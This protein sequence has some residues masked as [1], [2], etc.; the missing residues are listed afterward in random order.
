M[1]IGDIEI[2]P[3]RDGT[4]WEL[5]DDMLHRPG[6][7]DPW[8][9][10]PGAVDEHGRLHFDVGGFLIRS[11]D[12]LILV[13]AGVGRVNKGRHQGGKFLESLAAYGVQPQDIT[14]VLFTHLHFDHVGWAAQQGS[15]I[16]TNAAYRV[17]AADWDFFVETPDAH[18]GALSKLRPLESRLEL[19]DQDLTLAPGIDAR[20][21]PGHTPGSTVYIVSSHGSRALLLGDTVHTTAE[22]SETD[23][24]A[25]MDIDRAA[26]TAVRRALSEELADS[27]DLV[28]AAHFPDFRFGRVI[29]GADNTRRFHFL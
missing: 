27:P 24:E 14:D 21:S 1:R 26:G 8:S 4:T 3:V 7:E 2:L 19:F 10:H 20:H 9:C 25:L 23:W 12:R 17:H 22:L 28:T 18:P 6:V 16:F 13:D 29:T 15:V 11:N 5:A